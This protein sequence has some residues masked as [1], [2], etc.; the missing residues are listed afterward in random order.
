MVV[1]GRAL[2]LAIGRRNLAGG[3]WPEVF[4]VL[5]PLTSRGGPVGA[6]SFRLCR[7]LIPH[8][9]G[10]DCLLARGMVGSDVQKLVNGAQLLAP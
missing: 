2:I 3:G 10:S 9:D 4:L 1:P 5:P 8:K 7:R 6:V